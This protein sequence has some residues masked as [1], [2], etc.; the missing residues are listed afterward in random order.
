MKP[1]PSPEAHAFIAA[2]DAL[3]SI[4]DDEEWGAALE[5][6]RE[7][8]VYHPGFNTTTVANVMDDRLLIP[9]IDAHAKRLS[10]LPYKPR[11]TPVR[12]IPP[13]P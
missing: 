7:K 6:V 4:E 13:A 5:A 8:H 9:W 2:L 12:H 10:N 3:D 11:T 1:E